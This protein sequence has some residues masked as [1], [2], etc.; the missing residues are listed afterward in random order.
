[1][2]KKFILLLL[3]LAAPFLCVSM[4]GKKIKYGKQIIYEGKVVKNIPTGEG[5][6]TT[7]ADQFMDILSG[8]FVGDG[9]VIN[10]QLK[11]PSGW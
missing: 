9:S 5:T 1:M 11:F 2:E 10:A 7:S 8:T 6:L 4:Q 3:L